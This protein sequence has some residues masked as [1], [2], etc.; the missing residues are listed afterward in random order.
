MAGVSCAERTRCSRRQTR[1]DLRREIENR[2]DRVG[3]SIPAGGLP[4]SA[5]GRVPLGSGVHGQSAAP[6]HPGVDGPERSTCAGQ[7][8]HLAAVK[9]CPVIGRMCWLQPVRQMPSPLPDRQATDDLKQV[10]LDRL[11]DHPVAFSLGPPE[12]HANEFLT[13][14]GKG[15]QCAVCLPIWHLDFSCLNMRFEPST[16]G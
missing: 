13:S 6:V 8:Q 12:Q 11:G 2:I 5:P 7:A 1:H 15:S 4:A 9:P 3:S 10:M 14:A 16:R